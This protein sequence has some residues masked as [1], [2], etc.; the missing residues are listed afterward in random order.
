[1]ASEPPHII[2]TEIIIAVL[3]P[4]LSAIR[5]NIQPPMG[6]IRNPAANTPAV[7]SNCTVGLSDGKKAWAK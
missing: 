2:S 1:M 4:F 3:R 5:P 7:L 6:R